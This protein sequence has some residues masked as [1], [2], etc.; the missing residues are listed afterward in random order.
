MTCYIIGGA[1]GFDMIF[2]TGSRMV[3]FMD[4]GG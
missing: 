4:L 2:S 1:M 3:V